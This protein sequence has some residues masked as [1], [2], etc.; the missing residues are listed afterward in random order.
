MKVELFDELPD[1]P[2]VL[3]SEVGQ[4]GPWI[5]VRYDDETVYGFWKLDCSHYLK[6]AE[7]HK[8]R[9]Q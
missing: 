4:Y 2:G 6:E 1:L 8:R 3:P 7:K 9:K 5:G